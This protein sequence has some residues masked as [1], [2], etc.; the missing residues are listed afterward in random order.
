MKSDPIYNARRCAALSMFSLL[1]WFGFLLVGSILTSF[2]SWTFWNDLVAVGYAAV[3]IL[4]LIVLLSTSFTAYWRAVGAAF[5]QPLLCLLPMF[6]VS[7]SAGNAPDGST[8]IFL[9]VSIPVAILTAAIF[10][11]SVNRVGVETLGVPTTT[12]LKA[13]LTNW[14]EDLKDPVE[15]LFERFGKERSV[16]FSLLVFKTADGFS[17]AVTVS[18]FHPGPFKNLGSSLLPF[19]VQQ[20]LEK[21][22]GCCVAVPHG[23]FGHEYD[24]SSERQNQKVLRNMVSSTHFE[25]FSPEATRF[26]RARK[27]LATASCQIFGDCAV[28]ILTLAPETTEDFPRE[29]G[30]Y[31]LEEVSRLGLA[32]VVVINAH[33]SINGSFDV[34]SA[35]APLKEAASDVVRKASELKPL[36]F[37]VGAAK[38]VPEDYAVEAGMGPGGICALVIKVGEQTCAYVTI[39]GNNMISG[40]RDRILEVLTELHV[41]VGEVLTT[42]THA[43]N[44]VIRTAR[45]YH[46]LGE[47]M[48]PRELVRYIKTAVKEALRNMKPA[49]AAWRHGV[50]ADVNVIGEKQ[51]EELSLLAD[52]ALF[53]A[54]RT[55]L[56]LF[57]A[58]GL[59]FVLVLAAF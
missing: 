4:R 42:D 8:S 27:G 51:I 50:V 13:F 57:T 26:V 32:H 25:A 34:N 10:V 54:K 43:V 49:S 58:V 20:A 29:V 30:D 1:L 48:P 46:A 5:T 35:I 3:S 7:Y 18:S 22:L 2:V 33:N 59:F 44:A 9:L 53:R 21:K 31:I 12:V 23:L 14:M 17:G 38:V 55:A 47:A 52:R 41:D 36:P 6:Y 28:V 45:G 11:S 37:E 24:L 19:L 15:R 39:D 56:S 16:D 40:L